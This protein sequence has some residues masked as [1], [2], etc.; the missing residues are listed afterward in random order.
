MAIESKEERMAKEWAA[1]DTPREGTDN[2]SARCLTQAEI[3]DLLGFNEENPFNRPE[4]KSEFPGSTVI[5]N[6]WRYVH[7]KIGN[8][9]P[10]CGCKEMCERYGTDQE[11]PWGDK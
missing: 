5:L 7:V 8:P 10:V 11:C 2:P 4:H 6:E 1:M 3:D 9:I